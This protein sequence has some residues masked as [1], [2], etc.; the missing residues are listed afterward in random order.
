MS[1]PARLGVDLQ[2]ADSLLQEGSFRRLENVRISTQALVRRMGSARVFEA[3]DNTA[4]RT[5]GANTKWATIPA[6]AQLL[7]P[8]GS[9]ALRTSFVATRPAAAATAFLL[10]S[11]PAA[12][13]YH[14]LRVILS[15]DGV[16]TVEWRDSAG[17]TH[18]VAA[19]AVSDGATFHLLAIFDAPSGTFTVYNAGASTGTP[20]TGLASTL[21]LAQDA[22]VIWAVG[23]E[24]ETSAAVTADTFFPGAIDALELFSM[25]GTRP[26]EGSPS[27]VDTMRKHTFRQWPNQG[28]A[29]LRFQYGMDEASGT[30][31]IDSSD[32]K[33]HGTYVGAPSSSSKVARSRP[34]GNYVGTYQNASG[35]TFNLVAA[36]GALYYE[37]MP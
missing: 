24:K 4:S 30:S 14:V 34:L 2:T 21:Q 3:T 36:G 8:K 33:N 16:V 12:Q 35:N 28:S 31:M 13:T 18:S 20:L 17:A 10:S 5:F 22:G 7:L 27:L 25:P 19:A 23:I 32:W 6:A 9:W 15:D 1:P 37:A 11:R 26:A 29:M